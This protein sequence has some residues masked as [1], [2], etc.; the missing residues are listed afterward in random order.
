M[1]GMGEDATKARKGLGGFQIA[2]LALAMLVTAA[3]GIG[4]ILHDR[5]EPVAAPSVVAPP[6]GSSTMVDSSQ[7]TPPQPATTEPDD[8]WKARWSE[9]GAKWGLSFLGGF[10]IGLATRTFLKAVAILG[11]LAVCSVLALSYF[12]VVNIDLS[13][14]RDQWTTHGEWITQQAVK[15]R[16]VL[17]SHLPSS[18]AAIVGVG[19][20]LMRK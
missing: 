8:A 19:V 1:S 6:D 11:A 17:W 4:L 18:T 2:A 9:R 20:G 13:T 10:A 14:A 16:D 15:L 7:P 3:G 12:R 5:A